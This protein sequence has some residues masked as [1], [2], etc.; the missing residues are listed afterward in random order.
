[1]GESLRRFAVD[2]GDPEEDIQYEEE[3]GEIIKKR[4]EKFKYILLARVSVLRTLLTVLITALCFGHWLLV[5]TF[6]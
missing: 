3:D 4:S 6:L 2:P 5:V 1:M